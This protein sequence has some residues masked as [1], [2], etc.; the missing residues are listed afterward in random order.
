MCIVATPSDNPPLCEISESNGAIP[1]PVRFTGISAASRPKLA[2][3]NVNYCHHRSEI[4][5]C[6]AALDGQGWGSDVLGKWHYHCTT[7]EDQ[8]NSLMER[9]VMKLI[10]FYSALIA[11][12]LCLWGNIAF[13]Q[14]TSTSQSR[15][16]GILIIACG[17]KGLTVDFV[18]GNCV[19]PHGGQI[20]PQN[21]YQPFAAP[22]PQPNLSELIMRCGA[23]GRSADFVTGRC[24]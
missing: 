3:L 20:N 16:E 14:L 7:P 21:L 13:P 15:N 11:L 23:Q 1:R 5:L 2:S 17:S 10:S 22:L 6:G 4:S 18:T 8:A 9:A 24:M 19:M 12:I